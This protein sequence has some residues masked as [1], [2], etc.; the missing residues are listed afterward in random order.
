MDD[1]ELDHDVIVCGGG[2]AGLAATLW[3]GRYRRKTLL[4]DG[5]RQRNLAAESS[6]GYMTRDGASPNELLERAA[7]DLARY[8]TIETARGQVE[9]LSASGDGFVATIGGRKHASQR[10]LLATGVED[11]FPDIPGF[12]ELYGSAI[13]HCPCCDGYE[14]RDKD[15]IAIGWGEHVAGYALD[16]LEWGA[17]VGLIT[18]GR[19]AD[20]GD[21]CSMALQRHQVPVFEEEITRF[22]LEG[23]EMKGAVLASGRF[24]PATLAFF[25]IDHSPRTQLAIELGCELDDEGYVKVDGRGQTSVEGVYA[26]GDVTPGE[27]LIQVAAAQGAV[28]GIACAMSL[29]GGTTA[30]GAPDPG[31]DPEQETG[32]GV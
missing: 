7:G 22:E 27:Q 20:T 4:I 18:S 23:K 25:S 24:V 6:H 26:A 5:G 12:E 13:F 19:A 28:A 1:I 8:P 16:L 10:V 15:V 32:D 17:R 11:T 9:G 14:A 30:P 21:A 2:P 29:R 3:L 31:P